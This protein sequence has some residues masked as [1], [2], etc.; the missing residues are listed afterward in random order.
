MDIECPIRKE[1]LSIERILPLKG[2]SKLNV[3][4]N[5]KPVELATVKD[6]NNYILSWIAISPE[7]LKSYFL[8]CKEYYKSFFKSSN[9]DK[10]ALISRFIN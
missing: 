10:L 2:S 6:G 1:T 8:I 7:D 5:G 9:T 4:L 3:S